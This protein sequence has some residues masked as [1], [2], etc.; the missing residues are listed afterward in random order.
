VCILFSLCVIG[1]DYKFKIIVG[2]NFVNGDYRSA[3]EAGFYLKFYA[4]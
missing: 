3:A 4:N 1:F 2:V